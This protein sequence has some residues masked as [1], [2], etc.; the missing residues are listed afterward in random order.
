LGQ[1]AL[2][3][4]GDRCRDFGRRPE[5]VVHERVDRILHLAPGA[6]GL[7][8]LDPLARAPLLTDGLADA[9]EL[10]GH[11]LVGGNDFIERFGDLAVDPRPGAGELYPE[12]SPAHVLE[13]F[14]ELAPVQRSRKN[15]RIGDRVALAGDGSLHS[16]LHTDD[17]GS[18]LEPQPVLE[19]HHDFTI[20]ANR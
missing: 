18:N 9:L 6:F 2:G 8:E 10:T 4:R 11:A 19:S 13:R 5:E 12:V 17:S 14:E 15:R 16:C 7:F 1:V 3:D 20:A